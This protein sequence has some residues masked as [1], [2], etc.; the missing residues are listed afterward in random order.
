MTTLDPAQAR[1]KIL[2]ALK[3]EFMDIVDDG[4]TT[5]EELTKLNSEMT[6]F[7]AEILDVFR[8]EVIADRGG[9]EFDV[10]LRIP[11][12]DDVPQESAE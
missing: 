11:N 3:E 12:Y 9:D 2:E 1:L 6:D 5:I 4:N 10:R 8:I 7:A